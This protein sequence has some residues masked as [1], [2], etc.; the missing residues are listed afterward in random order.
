MMLP[1]F[2]PAAALLGN[3]FSSHVKASTEE[4]ISLR[5]KMWMVSEVDFPKGTEIV[6]SGSAR[7]RYGD[8]KF[9]DVSVDRNALFIRPQDDPL[10]V[11]GGRSTDII[12]TLTDGRRFRVL[13]QEISKEKNGLPELHKII[14]LENKD[15]PQPAEYLRADEVSGLRAE[16]EVLHKYCDPHASA[17]AAPVVPPVP[18]P[19]L[20]SA[21]VDALNELRFFDYEIYDVKGKAKEF[22]TV[23]F[24]NDRFTFVAV[25]GLEIPTVAALR[26]GKF[27]KVE[28]I[29]VKNRYEMPLIDEGKVQVGKDSFK[30]RLRGKKL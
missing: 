16:N 29:W 10:P 11:G 22:K 15:R 9:W 28:A 13:A 4:A 2:L 25:N 23:I 24:R 26:D 18:A 8:P 30:F 21:E 12:V 6:S 20:Q 19:G 3:L 7:P 17:K 1:F 5:C 14:D 27:T